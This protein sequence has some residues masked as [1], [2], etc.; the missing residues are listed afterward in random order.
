MAL[1]QALPAGKTVRN[2]G[3]TNFLV[4]KRRGRRFKTSLATRKKIAHAARKMKIPVLTL[5]ALAVGTSDAIGGL[6]EPGT[7]RQKFNRF[8]FHLLKNYTGI[9]VFQTQ[10][11]QFNFNDLLRG[12]GTLAG[13]ALARRSGIFKGA[14]K[15]LT[16]LRL[17]VSLS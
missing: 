13:V 1:P 7:I 6:M 10:A 3:G 12:T 17:P 8:G 5:G 15:A 16:K 9:S 11:P 2:I 4:S 14:N